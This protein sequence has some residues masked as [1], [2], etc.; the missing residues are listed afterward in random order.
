MKFSELKRGF[1]LFFTSLHVWWQRLYGAWQLSKLDQPVVTIFGG[2]RPHDD[3]PVID[4]ARVL[5]GMLASEGMSIVTGG[6]PGLMQAANCG[7]ADVYR[8]KR[9]LGIGVKGIDD[10]FTNACSPVLKVN[11]LF[12]RKWLL[13]RHS[14]AFI[15]F[16]GGISTADELFEVL[17]LIK[18]GNI[19]PLPVILIGR[20]FWQPLIDWLCV[21]S[22][23]AGFVKDA[24]CNLFTVTDDLNEVVERVKAVQ[25]MIKH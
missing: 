20:E 10:G 9:T 18:H 24:H 19:P 4:Q 25:E 16:P 3:D 15:V 23:N 2:T 7:A 1:F 21:S 8:K 14:I 22:R 13:I 11:H 6:G 17:N 12:L 5:A